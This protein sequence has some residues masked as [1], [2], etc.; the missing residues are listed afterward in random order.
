MSDFEYPNLTAIEDD[1]DDRPDASDPPPSPPRKPAGKRPIRRSLVRPTPS[2][3]RA[4]MRYL[5]STRRPQ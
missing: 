1:R 5:A 2:L 4:A 3:L